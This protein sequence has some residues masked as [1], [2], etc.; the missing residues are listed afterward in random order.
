M[1]TR[2]AAAASPSPFSASEPVS[3][4]FARFGLPRAW[5]IDRDALEAAYLSRAAAVHPDRFVGAPVAEQR[6]AMEESTALNEGYRVLRDPGR[7]AEYLCKLGGIDLDVTGGPGGAPH[8]DQVFLMDM[9]E[10][11]EAVETARVAGA[12]KLD[13]LRDEVEAEADDVL[14]A[15]VDALEADDV[16]DAAKKLVA[17]RYLQRLLDEIE[18]EERH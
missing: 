1:S 8:M 10:R 2:P 13:A 15:A 6:A 9:I 4:H 18:G 12:A 17:R 16:F 11:R 7:R 14:D 3:D 5:R